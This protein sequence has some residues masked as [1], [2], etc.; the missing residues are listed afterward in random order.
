MR[1]GAMG[2]A[3]PAEGMGGTNMGLLEDARNIQHKDPAARSLA[4]VM[5][6]YRQAYFSLRFYS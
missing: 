1:G 3:A 2:P 4:E 5:L 6:L